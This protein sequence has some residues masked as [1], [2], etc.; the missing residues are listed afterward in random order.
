MI[1]S[2]PITPLP[3]L[4]TSASPNTCYTPSTSSSLLCLTHRISAG[5]RAQNGPTRRRSST[6]YHCRL[7]LL[8]RGRQSRQPRRI[9]P[10]AGTLA[11]SDPTRRKN[12]TSC[13]PLHVCFQTSRSRL[14]QVL[15]VARLRHRHRR[16]R[17]SAGTRAQNDPTH[18]RSSTSCHRHPH[19][20]FRKTTMRAA[21]QSHA[22]QSWHSQQLEGEG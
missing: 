21:R 19:H 3:T 12:S 17:T 5:T 20:G 4:I 13:H 11:Q 14:L 22:G 8:L 2:V 1:F 7:P 9:R 18:R 10:S 15:Q 16:R 6:S